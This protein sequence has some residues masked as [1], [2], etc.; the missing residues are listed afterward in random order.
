M[1][2]IL[3]TLVLAL[4]TGLGIAASPLETA[5]E[6]FNSKSARHELGKSQPPLSMEEVVAA[7]RLWQPGPDTPVSPKLLGVFKQIA[8]SKTL[9][10]RAEFELLTGYDRGGK[11]VFDVWSVRIRIEREDGSSYAFLIRESVLGSRTLEEEVARIERVIE[12]K[13]MERM[14]GGY[15]IIERVEHLK[16]RIR[17]QA[18]N[19]QQE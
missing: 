11:F 8:E 10:D 4:G 1:K 14:V 9:P 2:T 5:I 19:G 17:Q 13:N 12:D 15:R 16:S 3:V 18:E 7:I 6:A